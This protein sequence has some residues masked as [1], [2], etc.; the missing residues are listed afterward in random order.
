[1]MIN[2]F[3]TKKKKI[4]FLIV[5]ILFPL[6][7][8]IFF[9]T[10]DIARFG[11]DKQNKI[12]LAIKSIIPPHYLRKI[13]DNVYIIPRLKAEIEKLELQV[14][15]FEQ[16]NEGQKFDTKLIKSDEIEYV[17]NF[18]FLPYKKLD[19]SLGWA[20][21]TNSLRAH[22][23]EIYNE[24]LISISGYGKIIYSNKN[25]L[26]TKNLNFIDLP[27]NIGD[28]LKKDDLKL[29]GIRDLYISNDQIIISMLTKSNLGITINL[30]K[31]EFNL[32]KINFELFFESKEFWENY[33]VFSGGRV[34]KF[35][36]DK[37]LFSIGF[38]KNYEAPQNKKSL[39]G[40]IVAIDL[41]TS[42]YELISYGH[43]NPQGLYFNT[44]NNLVINTEHGP[45]GGDEINFN[46]LDKDE[47]K[48]FGWPR[49]SYGKAYEGEEMFFDKDTFK[50]K[51][52][53]LGFIEPF[54]YFDPSIGISEVIY[55]NDNSFCKTR[56][57]MVSSLRANSVYIFEI[58]EDFK[59]IILERR[60]YLEGN[61]I[62]DINYD[63]D[64]NMV[65]LL[66]EG[67]PA[68]VTIKN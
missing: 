21:E 58:S 33:N 59:K 56:C 64:L 30:Y 60:I 41:N 22:Y 67:V 5:I 36:D 65:I 57:L 6:F 19:T 45:K 24:Y 55:L 42:D 2:L 14:K 35:V 3:N 16:G 7:F 4:I 48:N 20:A 53:E 18:F 9:L 12:I 61:R 39:L 46:F 13:R 34:E 15:K 8:Y 26:L 1:M 37:I 62:R 31:A 23:F 63:K 68:I 52:K 51:H 40:K 54:K 49:V 50:K 38:S 29:I 11:Y 27:N 25:N 32:K 17:S 43:R 10:S 66:S 44:N 28:I 47:D